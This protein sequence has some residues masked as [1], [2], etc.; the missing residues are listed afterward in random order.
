MKNIFHLNANI[1]YNLRSRSELYCRNPKTVK[2][3]AAI[4]SYFAPKIW[5]SV[6]ETIKISKSLDAFK[7]KIR[8]SEPDCPSR[9]CKTY[10]QH[11]GFMYFFIAYFFKRTTNIMYLISFEPMLLSFSCTLLRRQ[12]D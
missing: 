9:L 12:W 8:Q 7:Y 3:G 6:P 2:Y 1:P 5:S 11:V 10:L 4:I